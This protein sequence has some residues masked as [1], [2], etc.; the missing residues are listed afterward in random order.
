[1]K[2]LSERDENLGVFIKVQPE[3]RQ[4]G[5]KPL[6]ERDE[7]IP[8]L[9]NETKISLIVGMKPLSERDENFN[10]IKLTTIS[11]I[12]CRNEATL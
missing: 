12:K 11:L 4:V 6:S 5:M 7:N 3:P 10:L 1:M 8:S 2:P 9:L